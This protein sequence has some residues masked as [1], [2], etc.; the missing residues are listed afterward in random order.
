MASAVWS[1][2]MKSM[3]RC[4]LTILSF[5]TVS[6]FC[7]SFIMAQAGAIAP[8]G[9]LIDA[10]GVLR[11]QMN[12]DPTGKLTQQRVAAARAAMDPKLAKQSKLR[13]VSLTRLEAAMQAR[14]DNGQKPT[15]DMLNLAGLTRVKF[16][17]F[18]PESNE[19]VLAGPSEAFAPDALGYARGLETGAPTLQLEDLAVALRAFM[20]PQ[21]K[22]APLVSVSIDPTPE[23][24]KNM[25]QF[26]NQ[27][28]SRATPNQTD[29]ITKGLKESLGLQTV[30]LTG[31]PAT[32][33]MAKVLLEADYRMKLIG[34]GLEKPPVKMQSW[35]DRATS[36]AV[37]RNAL[38]RWYFVPD[39]QCVR[40]SDDDQ[41]M[42]LVGDGVKLLG[43]D[44][45][46]KADGSRA[47]STT[48]DLASK[49]FTTDFTKNY[50]AI[51]KVSPVFGQMRN[52]IDL[53]VAAAFIKD[54]GYAEKAGWKMETLLDEKKY[55]VETLNVP[56]Q[57]E[58]AVAA[59]WKG[60]R[61]ATPIGGGVHIE[62]SQALM[63]SNMLTDKD[64][65]LAAERKQID[66]KQLPANQWWWD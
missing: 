59:I 38:Q 6:Q 44:E 65:K 47:N 11:M 4:L 2:I 21:G 63:T 58:T 43:S 13:K 3:F 19:I 53:L 32:T 20:G 30:R 54:K 55:S 9:V 61:L 16:V 45:L 62:P 57:V 42:E 15:E 37:A 49:G 35:V 27:L 40:V 24:L 29:Y 36:G 28:G 1:S 25:Q 46:V 48:V 5:A 41:A 18:L 64:G 51:A 60:N 33:H 56:K 10:D 17:F 52:A 31:V 7:T 50:A 22:D 34:I 66:V 26:L 23:G 8:A 14:L 12:P 39:Y